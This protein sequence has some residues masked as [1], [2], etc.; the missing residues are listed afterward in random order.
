MA[1]NAFST[2]VP[3]SVE[4]DSRAK[5]IF[6]FF[7]LL[8]AIAAHGK[9]NGLGGRKLSRMAAWWAFEFKDNGTGFDGGYKTWI[10]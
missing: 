8:S 2:F 7:D 5:I 9:T 3:L 1:R 6:S 4:H 10:R